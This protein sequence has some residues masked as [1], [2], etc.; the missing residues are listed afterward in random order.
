MIVLTKKLI[1]IAIFSAH[2]I[3][4]SIVLCNNIPLDLPNDDLLYPANPDALLPEPEPEKV[5]Y[6][7]AS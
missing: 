5:V 6:K 2:N 3:S 1:K 7:T 4:Y